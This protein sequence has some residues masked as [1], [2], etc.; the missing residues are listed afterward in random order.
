MK[1]VMTRGHSQ[2]PASAFSGP[3]EALQVTG[4]ELT[5]GERMDIVFGPTVDGLRVRIGETDCV[6]NGLEAEVVQRPGTG[7]EFGCT[8]VT[9]TCRARQG[10]MVITVD[11]GREPPML[12]VA[13][14]FADSAPGDWSWTIDHHIQQQVLDYLAV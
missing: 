4:T 8:I 14:R 12:S 6:L 2:T 1:Q 13:A 7:P 9:A 11:C 10:A 5:T 3:R